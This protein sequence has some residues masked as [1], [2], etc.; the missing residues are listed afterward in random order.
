MKKEDKI[1]MK[2]GPEPG[3]TTFTRDVVQP[4]SSS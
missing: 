1:G 2:N 3:I 4:F